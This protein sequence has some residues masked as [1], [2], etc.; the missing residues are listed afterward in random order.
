MCELAKIAH[1]ILRIFKFKNRKGRDF[2]G[3]PV[4]K[5]R[6]S[7]AGGMIQFLIGEPRFHMPLQCPR[8]ENRR[9]H[10]KIRVVGV[11]LL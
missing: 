10:E 4:I 6:A 2:H 9:G 1:L 8:E 11:Y 7:T 5:T 3:S